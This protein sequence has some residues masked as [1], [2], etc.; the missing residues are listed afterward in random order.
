MAFTS[1]RT[2]PTTWRQYTGTTALAAS[3]KLNGK[4]TA[5]GTALSTPRKKR[6]SSLAKLTAQSG[7]ADGVVP[8]RDGSWQ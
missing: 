1:T 4:P 5:N 7:N 8:D 2:S 3:H 6:C